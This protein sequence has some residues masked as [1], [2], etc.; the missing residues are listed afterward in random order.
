ML[1][2]KRA[3]RSKV[4]IQQCPYSKLYAEEVNKNEKL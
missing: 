2:I 3:Y 1:E 4:H